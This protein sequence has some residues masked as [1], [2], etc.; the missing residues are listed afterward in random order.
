MSSLRVLLIL[1]P[2]AAFGQSSDTQLKL[3]EEMRGV[4]ATL[5]RLVQ[6][7]EGMEKSQ[8]ATLAL[9]QLQLYESQLRALQGQQ[10]RL[11]GQERDQSRQASSLSE[12]ARALESGV[13]ATG[14]QVPGAGAE[15]AVRAEMSERVSTANRLLDETR[16]R[17]QAIDREISNLRAR[18]GQLEKAVQDALR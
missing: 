10:E 12:S 15:P 14:L 17:K 11:T 7:V 18:I 6:L 2:A 13:S 9:T 4:R 8:R 5:D 1:V 3:L 16:S